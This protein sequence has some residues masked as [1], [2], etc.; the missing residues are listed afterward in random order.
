MILLSSWEFI[1]E[2][3]FITVGENIFQLSKKISAPATAVLFADQ[4]EKKEPGNGAGA[5]PIRFGK[6]FLRNIIKWLIIAFTGVGN[7]ILLFLY[8]IAQIIAYSYSKKIFHDQL[9][10]TVIG[11]RSA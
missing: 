5:A 2:S 9:S 7:G 4:P 3:D 10:N 1:T 8:I 6:T 11:E